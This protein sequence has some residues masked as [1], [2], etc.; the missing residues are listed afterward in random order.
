MIIA[1]IL[2]KVAILSGV[3]LACAGFAACVSA[4]EPLISDE[5][6]PSTPQPTAPPLSPAARS[7]LN[8]V[9]RRWREELSRL[10]A[11]RKQ[12]PG[13]HSAIEKQVAAMRPIAERLAA[14]AT[15]N[16]SPK[17]PDSEKTKTNSATTPPPKKVEHGKSGPPRRPDLDQLDRDLDRTHLGPIIPSA[18]RISPD[19]KT[20]REGVAAMEEETRKLQAL[21]QSLRAA[22][23]AP[24][25]TEWS[26]IDQRIKRVRQRT[27][28]L[29]DHPSTPVSN[30]AP[31]PVI[32]S[33]KA[34]ES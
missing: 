5:T 3:G 18:A 11:I 8:D 23:R 22:D 29:E 31:P 25:P 20:V 4:P 28:A 14:S 1:S 10:E 6:R 30:P 2:M 34:K 33:V 32:P 26:E 9:Y 17:G 16:S 13:N 7:R 21:L 19:L 12:Q 27:N 24:T 15:E